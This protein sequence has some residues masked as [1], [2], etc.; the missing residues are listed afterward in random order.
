MNWHAR[1]VGLATNA[2][3]TVA[4]RRLPRNIHQWR[5]LA[6]HLGPHCQRYRK[7][8]GHTPRTRSNYVDEAG[9]TV[10]LLVSVPQRGGSRHQPRAAP[11]REKSAV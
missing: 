6:W 2:R 10:Q 4:R 7:G 11:G 1:G 5:V 9:T 3:R 8:G